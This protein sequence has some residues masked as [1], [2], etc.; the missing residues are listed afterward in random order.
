[1]RTPMIIFANQNTLRDYIFNTD[2]ATSIVNDVVYNAAEGTRILASGRPT[3]VHTLLNIIHKIT[4]RRAV[5][6]FRPDD[7][8]SQNITFASQVIYKP[9]E[10][11]LKT[12]NLEEGIKILA[13]QMLINDQLSLR[14]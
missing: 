14:N 13:K 5:H 11:R 1:M 10:K 6:S 12:T 2:L 4:G 7:T 3:S 9:F 8:N